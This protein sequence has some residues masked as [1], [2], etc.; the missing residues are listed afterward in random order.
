M[1]ELSLLS[2]SHIVTVLLCITVII[3]IPK[4]FKHSSDKNKKYLSFL[5]IFLLLINQGMGFYREGIISGRWQDGLPLHLCDFSTMAII[6]YFLTTKRDFF[7]FAFFLW[8]CR[9][10][11][12]HSYSRYCLWFS[13]C[14][15]Y[16]EPNW[17][18]NDSYGSNLCNGH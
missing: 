8:H 9:W 10:R 2:P 16:T 4:Y 3:A 17:P 5:I 18:H 6:L 13:L 12:V 15:I 1:N 14:R 7:V 11:Y